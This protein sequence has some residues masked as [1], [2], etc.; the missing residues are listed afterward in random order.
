MKG[1][2]RPTVTSKM[3]RGG[4]PFMA[5]PPRTSECMALPPRHGSY[6]VMTPA[7]VNY[8]RIQ[9]H[10]IYG[11]EMSALPRKAGIDRGRPC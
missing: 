4:T 2:L 11:K 3:P 7:V 5:A 8:L 10:V 6:D 9:S 1:L